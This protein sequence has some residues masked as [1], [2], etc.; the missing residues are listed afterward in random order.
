[1]TASE[2]HQL[3]IEYN[4]QESLQQAHTINTPVLSEDPLIVAPPA[5]SDAPTFWHYK[6]LGNEFVIVKCAENDFRAFRLVDYE[7]LQEYL[8]DPAIAV[9]SHPH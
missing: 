8:G 1:M 7:Q 3:R 9:K 5:Y 2:L 4:I 6:A